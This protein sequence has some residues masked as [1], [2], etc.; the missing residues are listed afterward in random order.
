MHKISPTYMYI[1][2]HIIIY[3]IIYIHIYIYGY[4]IDYFIASR[5]KQGDFGV[6]HFQAVIHISII[7][8]EV[9]VRAL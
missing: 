3:I 4:S 8:G 9:A 5:P 7:H 1:Y 6:A 2:I